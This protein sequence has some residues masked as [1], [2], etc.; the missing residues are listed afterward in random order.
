MTASNEKWQPWWKR[1]N[2]YYGF[3]MKDEFVRGATSVGFRPNNRMEAMMSMLAAGY[4]RD[5][6]NIA[7][8]KSHTGK[9][10]GRPSE[11]A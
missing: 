11:G 9:A 5:T 8:P 2:D 4:V 10:D 3:D 7:L 6:S 1:A